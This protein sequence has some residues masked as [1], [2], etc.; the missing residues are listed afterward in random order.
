MI[1]CHNRTMIC[2]WYLPI[3]S[4]LSYRFQWIDCGLDIDTVALIEFEGYKVHDWD[5]CDDW[6][7]F[8]MLKWLVGWLWFGN[9]L[10]R[11]VGYIFAQ[12]CRL[13]V[14][15]FIKQNFN[16][17]NCGNFLRIFVTFFQWFK[18]TIKLEERGV[19]RFMGKWRFLSSLIN[20]CD[21]FHL[22]IIV[23]IFLIKLLVVTLQNGEQFFFL[24]FF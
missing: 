22:G 17:W 21:F 16:R 15:G 20:F 8:R 12:K 14:K 18:A 11:K 3:C 2:L 24:K 9:F 1:H 5:L 19:V 23:L 4:L 10:K 6:R 7:I 13:L